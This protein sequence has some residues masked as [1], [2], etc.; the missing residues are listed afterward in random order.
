MNLLELHERLKKKSNLKCKPGS[1][2]NIYEY[3][4]RS[5]RDKSGQLPIIIKPDPEEKKKKK[6]MIN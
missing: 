6:S 5:M 3:N 1:V 4:E 2:E